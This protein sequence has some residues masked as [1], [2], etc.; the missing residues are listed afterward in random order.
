MEQEYCY[1]CMSH[2]AEN[3]ACPNCGGTAYEAPV[4]HLKPGTVLREKYMIG[5]ALG[6]G[7]FG[8]TYVG[9]DLTLDMKIAVKE[10]YPNGL[11]NRNN[12]Y[13]NQVTMSKGNHGTDFER[14]MQ[15]FLSEARILAR[16][17]NEPGVVGVRDF[18]REN[19]TAYIVMEYL[20]G[21]TL[22]NYLKHKGTIPATSFAKMIDPIL[23]ALHDIHQQ[24]LIHRDISPDNI[25]MLHGSGRLKLLD[26][27]AAREMTGD[28]S[29]SV[30]L[31]PGYAPEEQYRS[32]GQQG[33]WTDVYAMC[34]TIYKCI[35]G[36]TPDE[37]IQRV[38][39]DELK[40]PSELGIAI[41]AQYEQAL[42]QG[43]QVK[44][45]DRIQSMDV[46][47]RAILTVEEETPRNV[48][49][50]RMDEQK[51]KPA[52]APVAETERTIYTAE[53]RTEYRAVTQPTHTAVQPG[54]EVNHPAPNRGAV[55]NQ[56]V[57]PN[58]GVV[59]NQGAAP[60]Q[61]V[62]PNRGVVPNQGAAPN[63]GVAPNRGVVPNQGVAPNQGAAPNQGVAPN[64][65]AAPTS[66]KTPETPKP[67]AEK[68][69][70]KGLVIA[71]VS[72]GA[73]IIL[74][75]SAIFA[76][77]AMMEAS[78]GLEDSLP[79]ERVMAKDCSTI[80]KGKNISGGVLGVDVVEDELNEK[81]KTYT[82][83]CDV[84]VSENGSYTSY[85]IFLRYEY[86][87]GEWELSNT[88]TIK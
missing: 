45:N 53:D 40:K 38:F 2:K 25:M 37:S 77:P 55:P 34:A 88:S 69:S 36:I 71:L 49:V 5:K 10:Y 51:N 63:Q 76:I 79:S 61:G 72:I 44:S 58:R 59:P 20:D 13:S 32:K 26:F 28:K 82:A 29:L 8:I 31:K 83:T 21:I 16:F 30:M 12:D 84:S 60:N 22:K 67:A 42:M 23:V 33:A 7:G 47:R 75:I 43:L 62:A 3:Q 4:H 19:G 85:T 27:G 50:Q 15:R 74:V 81:F 64:R 52:A 39:E 56:G 54:T 65:G 86:E 66:V 6:E 73:A 46:L 70:K 18:F 9:R 48:Q 41:P 68:K 57:A 24:G 35:T 78:S 80:L 1:L 14:E 11:S 17:C 87:D